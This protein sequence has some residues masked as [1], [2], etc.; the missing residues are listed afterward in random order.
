MKKFYFNFINSMNGFKISIKEHS[1]IAELLG[2]MVLIPYLI[3][4]KL[5]NTEKLIILSIYFFLLAFE[6]VNTAIEKLSDKITDKFDNDIKKVKD[7]SSSSVFLIL[8][9]LI[10]TIIFCHF[11]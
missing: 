5:D 4:S 7:L 6:I 11:Y 8:I 1:F 10:F 9:L 3:F 2:G